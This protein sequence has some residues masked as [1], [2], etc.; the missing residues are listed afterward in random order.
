M[1]EI[2]DFSPVPDSSDSPVEKSGPEGSGVGE[3]EP[4][5]C[6]HVMTPSPSGVRCRKC[7]EYADRTQFTEAQIR[8]LR[9]L[10]LRR[11]RA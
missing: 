11:P 8:R 4:E 10:K 3:S 7:G 9:K 5:K 2:P 6:V 1:S